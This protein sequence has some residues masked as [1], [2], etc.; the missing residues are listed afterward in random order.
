MFTEEL[1]HRGEIIAMLWQMN[2][3][4]ADMGWPSSMGRM[5]PPWTIW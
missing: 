4:P 5:D 1:H 3:Q 2:V